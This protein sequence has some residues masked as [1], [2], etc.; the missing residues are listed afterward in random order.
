MERFLRK[1]GCGGGI[2]P[3]GEGVRV[4]ADM[5]DEGDEE[6][7][8]EGSAKEEVGFNTSELGH[9][10]EFFVRNGAAEGMVTKPGV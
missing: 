9:D 1:K 7:V 8:V 6:M 5:V 4:G 2:L 10:V 3:L